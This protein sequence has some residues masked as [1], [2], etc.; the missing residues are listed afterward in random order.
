VTDRVTLSFSDQGVATVVLSHPPLNIYDLAMRDG[1]IESITAVRDNP[2]ARALLI[3]AEGSNFSVGADLAEFG[4]AS[5]IFEGRR[6]RW[7]RDPWLPLLGLSIPTVVALKG[8]AVGS[9]LEIALLCDIRIAATNVVLGLP[10]T[11][12]GMLPAA[13]GTQTLTQLVGP[14]AAAPLILTGRNFDA[15]E[16]VKLGIVS[17]VTEV[18]ELDK[19]AEKCAAQLALLEP[20]LAMKLRRCISASKDLPLHLGLEL[21]RRLALD[22]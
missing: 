11:K 18:A 2:D 5:S 10:E 4:S 3:R 1:L 13:G 6:I 9:G 7:D 21:E 22:I 12:L 19:A 15:D 8:Y 17:E 16:A 20:D 14:A